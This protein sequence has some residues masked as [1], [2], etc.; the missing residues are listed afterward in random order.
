MRG[1]VRYLDRALSGYPDRDMLQDSNAGFEMSRWR[2][3]MLRSTVVVL[4]L[5]LPAPPQAAMRQPSSAA[6]RV[7]VYTAEARE[8]KP[9]EEEQ[10]RLDSVRDVRE[11]LG[12]KAGLV[13]VQSASEAQVFVEVV[14]RETRDVPVGGF[15][16]KVLTRPVETIV[17]LRLKYGEHETDIK[18]VGQSGTR[19]AKDAAERVIRWIARYDGT[20]GSRKVTTVP[21]SPAPLP[22]QMSSHQQ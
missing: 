15:G 13:M 9:T 7:F 10:G 16:G 22:K 17:R 5:L 19:A 11:A 20:F 14:G 2:G 12:R 3:V 8:A 21:Q 18:G 4:T 6:P 1:L